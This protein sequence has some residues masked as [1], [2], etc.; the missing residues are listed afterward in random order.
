MYHSLTSCTP[1]CAHA[2]A[3]AGAAAFRAKAHMKQPS[4]R[5]S[6]HTLTSSQSLP[7]YYRG[8]VPCL[9]NSIN[10]TILLS[11]ATTKGLVCNNKGSATDTS[12]SIGIPCSN[13]T[14]LEKRHTPLPEL[15]LWRLESACLVHVLVGCC[16]T[17]LAEHALPQKARRSCFE[18]LHARVRVWLRIV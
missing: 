4:R 3:L 6:I 14:L 2:D 16:P 1:S 8:H 15:S 18:R 9:T 11:Y 17:S 12:N 5:G 7:R 13:T 10:S